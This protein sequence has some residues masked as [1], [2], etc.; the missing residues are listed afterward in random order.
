MI[1]SVIKL[2][3]KEE[4][5][6]QFLYIEIA[7]LITFCDQWFASNNGRRMGCFFNWVSLFGQTANVNHDAMAAVKTRKELKWPQLAAALCRL[8]AS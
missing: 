7:I 5:G 4:L 6:R 1:N 2:S 3:S 8:L